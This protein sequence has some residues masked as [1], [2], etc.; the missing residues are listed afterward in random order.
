L[1]D[2]TTN[3]QTEVRRS[4]N[5]SHK[6]ISYYHISLYRFQW[7]AHY[8]N[9]YNMCLLGLLGWVAVFWQ[10]GTNTLEQTVASIFRVQFPSLHFSILNMLAVGPFEILV[11]IQQNTCTKIQEHH[12]MN[13][14]SSENLQ[15][16]MVQ[17]LSHAKFGFYCHFRG[18]KGPV[19]RPRCIGPGE[20]PYPNYDSI[21]F[22]C[23]FS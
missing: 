3:P 9:V 14:N 20:G 23:N 4:K 22:Y 8:C 12:Y 17:I 10:T 13:T 11:P 6:N 5:H 21:L 2:S 16:Q 18:H 19:L 7:N 1:S 15:S